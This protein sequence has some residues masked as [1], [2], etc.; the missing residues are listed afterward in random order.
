[1]NRILSSWVSRLAPAFLAIAVPCSVSCFGQAEHPY[2]YFRVGNTADAAHGEPRAGFALMGGGADLDE[3]FAWMCERAGGGDFLVLRATGGDDYNPYVQKLCP[4]LNSVATLVI[5]N[6]A[7][8][9]DPFVAEKIRK[10]EAVFIAGGDQANYI[11]FWMKSP[12]QDA[13]NEDIARGV[14]LGGTSAGLAVM[15]EWAY[16]AQGDKP[17][18]P[19]LTGKLA[20]SDPYGARI[21]LAQGFLSIPVLRGIVTDTHFAKRDRMGRLLVF[22]ARLEE[23]DGKPEPPPGEGMRGIGV[24]ERAAVLLDPDGAARV[25]GHGAA[26]FID[27]SKAHGILIGGQ[28]RVTALHEPLT[29]GPYSVQKVEAGHAFGLKTWTGES[30]KYLLNVKDGQIVSSQ[31]GGTVY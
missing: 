17:D 6:R 5:P 25:I 3:A 11:N 31:K 4:K 15:G 28:F 2:K 29:F 13:L 22:L 26:Y 9:E 10:A 30:A 27:G 1:M 16:S 20:M 12:V 14:P 7:A 19:N 21:T 23:P 8:A 18:D 24:E